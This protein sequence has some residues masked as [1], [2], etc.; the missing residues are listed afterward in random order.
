MT[1][2]MIH[3]TTTHCQKKYINQN[4]Q[5]MLGRVRRVSTRYSNHVLL[6]ITQNDFAKKPAIQQIKYIYIYM[7]LK[8][9]SKHKNM[10]ISKKEKLP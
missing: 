9:Q 7:T 5:N 2:R 8:L 1:P 6:T 10:N 3:N 4:F